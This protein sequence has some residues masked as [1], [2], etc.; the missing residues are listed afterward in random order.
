VKLDQHLIIGQHDS[1]GGGGWRPKRKILS[2]DLR[3]CVHLTH[4]TIEHQ[5]QIQF[6]RGLSLKPVQVN[7]K[8][9]VTRVSSTRMTRLL[10]SRVTSMLKDLQNDDKIQK[11][12]RNKTEL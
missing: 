5:L 6:L 2:L 3:F 4:F 8:G 9:K 7:L 1:F 10:I 11:Q 12:K